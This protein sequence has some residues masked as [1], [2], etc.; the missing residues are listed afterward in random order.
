[1]QEQDGSRRL[2]LFDLPTR[3]AGLRSPVVSFALKYV[4]EIFW[5]RGIEIIWNRK[6]ACT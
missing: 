2:S 4:E 3:L 5:Q 1:M 6:L